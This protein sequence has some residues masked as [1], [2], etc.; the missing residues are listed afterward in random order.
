MRREFC[1]RVGAGGDSDR[2]GADRAGAGD[3]VRSVTNNPRARRGKVD[4]GVVVSAAEGVGPELVAELAVV[5]E[6]T[7]GEVVP[8][9]V[10]AEFRAGAALDVTGEQALSDVG[11]CAGGGQDCAHARKDAGVGIGELGG[12]FGEVPV[13]EAGKVFLSGGQP[14]FSEDAAHNPTVGAASEVDVL[15]GA[16]DREG[17]EQRGAECAHTGA[18]GGDEGA[19]DIPK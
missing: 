18:A 5:G 1:G 7:E 11:T 19:I 2:F 14:K 6:G 8:Q 9:T 17:A 13:E 15:E 10:V 16:V 12:Q 4:T 3:V